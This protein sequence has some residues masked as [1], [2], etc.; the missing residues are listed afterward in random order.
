MS[1]DAMVVLFARVYRTVPPAACLFLLVSCQT[2]P[3][4]PA[5]QSTTST[6]NISLKLYTPFY[7][8]EDHLRQLLANKENLDD[9]ARLF[10]EQQGYFL[11]SKAAN[12]RLLDNLAGALNDRTD[13]TLSD[14]LAQIRDTQWPTSTDSW[15]QTKSR[16]ANAQGALDAYPKDGIL[17]LNEFK[18]PVVS[19][20]SDAASS[21]KDHILEAAPAQF[22]AF[23]HFGGGHFFELYPVPL[24]LNSF[25]HAHF[26]RLLGRFTSASY[27]DIQS[28][29]HNYGRDILGQDNWARLADMY[30]ASYLRKSGEINS[31][32]PLALLAAAASAQAVGFDSAGATSLKIGLIETT[33]KTLILQGQIDFPVGINVDI[34]ASVSKRH[35][36]TALDGE[37]TPGDD[38]LIIVNVAQAKASRRVLTL[39]TIPSTYFWGYLMAN[40]TKQAVMP[41]VAEDDNF[42]SGDQPVG[43]SSSAQQATSFLNAENQIGQPIFLNYHISKATI[44][45][46]K[47]MTVHYYVIDRRKNTVFKSTFDVSE[48][49]RFQVGYNISKRDPKR[50]FYENEFDIEKDVDDFEKASSNVNLSQLIDDYRSRSGEAKLYLDLTQL[51]KDI[52]GDNNQAIAK[53]RANTFDARPLNDPRFDSVVAVYRGNGAMGSGFFVKP[54]VVLTNWHVVEDSKFVEMKMYDGQETFGKVLGKDVRLD[55]AL[56]KV[57]NRGK[58]VKF[59]TS[60]TIDVGSPTEAIGHPQRLEFSITRGIVSAVRNHA[61]INLPRGAGDKVLYIQTDAPINNGNSGGPLF[62]GDEVVGMNTW[63]YNKSVAEGLNFSVH[64]S[65]LVKFMNEHLPGFNVNLGEAN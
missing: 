43:S 35:L 7:D 50:E 47:L 41:S 40:N 38:L 39:K 44:L 15:P 33:S 37:A 9:A 36:N 62:V 22:N 21:L 27:R 19:A 6:Q 42:D 32:D 8:Q 13:A 3:T 2:V 12:Q 52:L 17:A 1:F 26:P 16:L 30:I 24:E 65:E 31:Q 34:P 64:Y 59:Y 51:R 53:V 63:G 4:P 46:R 10:I 5:P 28:I 49:E 61:S 29:A 18:N 45:A 54:D 14:A 20:L 11:A 56:V 48:Q 55:V 57:Q 23:D 25:I 58:P 60:N